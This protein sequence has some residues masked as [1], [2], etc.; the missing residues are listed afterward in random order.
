VVGVE[1]RFE[2]GAEDAVREAQRSVTDRYDNVRSD[3]RDRMEAA[4]EGFEA[5]RRAAREARRASNEPEGP[6]TPPLDRVV[7]D[8]LDTGM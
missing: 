2:H 5:G 7:D 3:V 4:R 1:T 8:E 6:T